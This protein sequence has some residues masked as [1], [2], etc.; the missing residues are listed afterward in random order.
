MSAFSEL[1]HNI[2]DALREFEM[3]VRIDAKMNLTQ[4]FDHRERCREVLDNLSKEIL[5][6]TGQ[7]RLIP[8]RGVELVTD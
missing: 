8:V 3:V 5:K 2:S 1:P 4:Q 7:N 6:H